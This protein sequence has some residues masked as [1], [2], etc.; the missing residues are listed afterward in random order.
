MEADQPIAI[1]SVVAGAIHFIGIGK[2]KSAGYII[3]IVLEVIRL[4]EL[5]TGGGDQALKAL[6][7]V[8]AGKLILLDAA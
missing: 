7:S 6:T 4:N 3:L 1:T 5:Q 8:S 2:D